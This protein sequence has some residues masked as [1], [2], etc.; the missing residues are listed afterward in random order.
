MRILKEAY[1]LFLFSNVE[2]V[3]ITELEKITQ[4]VRGT[5]FYHFK[6]K[7][8]LFNSVVSEVFLPSF[9]ITPKI[10]EAAN[11]MTFEDFIDQYKS[12][13]ERVINKI[14]TELQVEEPE[15]G[16]YNFLNQA[17]KYYPPFKKE[18]SKIITKELSVWNV[19]IIR[20]KKDNSSLCCDAKEMAYAFMLLSTGF[21]Y[22]KGYQVPS[23]FDCATLLKHLSRCVLV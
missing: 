1:R 10:L 16:Y 7:Q 4:K 13:E 11:D 9:E 5:L 6:N 22:N 2:K 12:P 14:T 3:T 8:N 19:V 17:Y 20:I 21:Y 15:M 18:Y 23:G